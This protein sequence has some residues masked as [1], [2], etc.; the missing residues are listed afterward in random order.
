MKIAVT[1]GSGFIGSHLVERLV[2]EGHKVKAFARKTSNIKLLE[3]L[4]VKLVY[5]DVT[6]R[7]SVERLVDDVDVVYHVAGKVYM[8]SK[9]EFWNVNVQGTVNMLEACLDR[10]I[11]RFVY[12]STIGVMG[13]V[14]NP[15]A[16]ETGVYNPLSPYDESKCK[17]EKTALWYCRENGVPVTVVRP[18][19]VYGPRNMYLL[20][21]YHWIQ[22]GDFRLIG[23][24]NNL[25][26]PCYIENFL[27]GVTLAAEKPRAIGEVYIIGDEKPVTW[28]EYVN[29]IA[30]ALGVNLPD[31]HVPV[32]VLR[33]VACFSEFKSWVFGSEPFLT[34]YWVEEITKNFAYDIAKA[35][36]ELGY[37]PK[38]S[39]KEGVSRTVEWYKQNG[40]LS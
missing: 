36:S 26:H 30:E 1:G 35:K 8:G 11:D 34:R 21:L 4:D 6:D 29:D 24:M 20:R 15:P 7:G 3:K 27:D 22:R 16:D 25:M 37:N 14:R 2:S 12:T 23:G 18:T 31:R 13:S 33:A 9:K 19:V 38:I 39:L 10:S 28:R 40:F 32:W 17:A 5:G